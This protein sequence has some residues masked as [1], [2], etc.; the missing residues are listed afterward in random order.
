MK[1]YTLKETET[2]DGQE[3]SIEITGIFATHRLAAEYLISK[4][5]KAKPYYIFGKPNKIIV[6]FYK[7]DGLFE[8]EA[9]IEDF[10]L[11]ED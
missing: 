2:K 1:V 8:Y 11:V 5:Y 4:G 9:N 7:R 3:P 6:D 10:E